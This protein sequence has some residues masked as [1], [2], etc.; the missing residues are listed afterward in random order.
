MRAEYSDQPG[1]FGAMITTQSELKALAKR[2]AAAGYQ[3]NTH[4]I[5]DSANIAVIRAYREAL[6]NVEDA[7]WKIEHAQVISM[8]DFSF[9]TTNTCYE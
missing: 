8:E 2:I 5:G 7:R 9:G 1:Q 4:A 3:M 6:A